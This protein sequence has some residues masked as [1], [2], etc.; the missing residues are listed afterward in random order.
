ML[1]AVSYLLTPPYF[2]FTVALALLLMLALLEAVGA[3]LTGLVP[4]SDLPE[5]HVPGLHWLGI[6]RVPLGML[7]VTWLFL[8]AVSGITIQRFAQAYAGGPMDALSA[9]SAALFPTFVLGGLA[10]SVL[11]RV[12][13]QDETTAV[14]LDQLVGR[15]A[16]LQDHTATTVHPA[17]ASVVD[18]HG[19]VHLVSVLAHSGVLL[20]GDEVLLVRR[21]GVQ[22]W[23]ML[24][25]QFNI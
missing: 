12:L 18:Q 3:G 5:H 17:R 4:D 22:F 7:I 20:P 15:R 16:T 1:Q 24:P 11:A 23:G 13:P 9:A 2:P 21:E 8:F 6:G 10:A 14:S 25:E 19:Q